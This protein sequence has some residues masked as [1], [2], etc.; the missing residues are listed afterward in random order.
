[1]GIVSNAQFFT[2]ALFS[3][4]LGGD[5]AGLG[6]HPRLLFYSY[7]CGRAKPGRFLFERS[8]EALAAVGVTAGEVL[9]I[10]NDM[11]NDVR[12]AGEVGF[13]TAL[14]AGD[15][16]SLRRRNGDRRVAGVVPDLV[17]TD[18][19]QLTQCVLASS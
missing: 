14:F 2:P 13:R 5:L 16:R 9:Y 11:L 7:R 12:P 19:D 8:R 6:F 18:L 15:E 1:M 17:L 4:L 10:G 3:A